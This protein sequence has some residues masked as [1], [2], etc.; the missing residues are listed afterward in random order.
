MSD[1][2]YFLETRVRQALVR[3]HEV[4]RLKGL[5]HAFDVELFAAD[6]AVHDLL[7]APRAADDARKAG[8]GTPE[9]ARTAQGVLAK[10]DDLLGRLQAAHDRGPQGGDA[11]VG[12]AGRKATGRR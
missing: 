8:A 6:R 1:V 11:P 9:G 12:R 2:P 4:A 3:A 7:G 10:L 5:T